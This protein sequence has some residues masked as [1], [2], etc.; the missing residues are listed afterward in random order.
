MSTMRTPSPSGSTM[1]G[2]RSSETSLSPS[3]Q[4]MAATRTSTSERASTSD[5]ARPRKPVSNLAALSL[6]IMARAPS[7]ESGA[8]SSE[9]SRSSSTNTPPSP[10][11]TADP[12]PP[13]RFTPTMVSTT[14]PDLPP[15]LRTMPCTSIPSRR[16]SAWCR[17]RMPSSSRHAAAN[18]APVRRLSLT[19]PV[20]VLCA[21]SGEAAFR[22]TG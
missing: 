22:A 7:G 4:H 3:A 20:S 2:F 15:A 14:S 18:S 6:P 5:A 19:R 16:A 17:A 11:M 13:S 10:T 1:T 21:M 12:N 9:T 8:S